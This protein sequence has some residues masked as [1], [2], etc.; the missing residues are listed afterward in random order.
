ML[1]AWKSPRALVLPR[2]ERASHNAFWI[3]TVMGRGIQGDCIRSGYG[4]PAKLPGFWGLESSRVFPLL[5]MDSES[6]VLCG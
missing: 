3:F 5:N 1:W 4:S 2:P 6:Q